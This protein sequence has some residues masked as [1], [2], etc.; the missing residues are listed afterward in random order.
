MESDIL[1]IMKPFQ[2]IAHM[3][4]QQSE[5]KDNYI[6]DMVINNKKFLK[7]PNAVFGE[8]RRILLLF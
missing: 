3:L 5:M 8:K 7:T 2:L 6:K 4:K 1:S